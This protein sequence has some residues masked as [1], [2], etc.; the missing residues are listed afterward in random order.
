MRVDNHIHIRHIMLYHYEKGWKAAQSFRDLNE[1][2]G[3]GTISES[4]CREWFAR[5]KSGD[6][7]LE[8]KSGRGRSS[9]FDDQALLTFAD[10]SF[11]KKF[12]EIAKWLC[13]FPS[14]L[15]VVEHNMT[16]MNM[17]IGTHFY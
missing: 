5:F 10:C 14:F 13:R 2:F 9:D 7:S 4:Q 17:I 1:L 16:N 15:V 6:T 12:V 3:E 11:A 8:D